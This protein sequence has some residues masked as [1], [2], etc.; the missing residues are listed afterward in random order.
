MVGLENIMSSSLTLRTYPSAL[1]RIDCPKCKRSAQY[2][3]SELQQRF[4]LDMLMID[5]LD[6]LTSCQHWNDVS[7]PCQMHFPDLSQQLPTRKHRTRA[8]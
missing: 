8:R 4:S 2:R 5:I 6:A 1:I 3:R 7:A